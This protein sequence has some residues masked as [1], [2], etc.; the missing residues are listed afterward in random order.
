MTR[1]GGG[2]GMGTVS[3]RGGTSTGGGGAAS[4]GAD[5]LREFVGRAEELADCETSI[6]CA[7]AFSAAMSAS[8]S[9]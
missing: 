9:D 5:A 1:S 3:G 7:A 2:A 4:S 6:D 8:F